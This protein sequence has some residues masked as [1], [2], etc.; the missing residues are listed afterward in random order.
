[1]RWLSIVR[2]KADFFFNLQSRLYIF[3]AE[4]YKTVPQPREDKR[5]SDFEFVVHVTTYFHELHM[6]LQRKG[7]LL[8][9]T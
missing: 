8:C 4:K 5:V 7:T 3:M 2:H 1:M 6:K 9:D